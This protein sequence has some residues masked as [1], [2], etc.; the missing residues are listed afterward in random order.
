M[1]Q[2]VLW[3]CLELCIYKW[4]IDSLWL[5]GRERYKNKI[6]QHRNTI[7]PVPCRYLSRYAHRGLVSSLDGDS[8]YQG[9][10]SNDLG[11]TDIIDPVN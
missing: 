1:R 8:S 10:V 2:Y 9:A 7:A 11:T 5:P 3:N 6:K 4:V